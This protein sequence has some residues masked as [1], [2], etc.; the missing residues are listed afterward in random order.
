[1]KVREDNRSRLSEAVEMALKLSDGFV[2]LVS[3]GMPD[4]ELTEKYV[5]P[6]CEISL[7]DI[8]P[9]LF[10]FNAPAGACPDC[11]GLRLPHALLAGARREPRASARGRGFIPWKSMKHMIQKAE[12]LAEKK[13]WDISRPFGELPSEAQEAMLYGSDEVLPLVFTD[14]SWRL[15]IQRQVYGAHPVDRKSATTRRNPKITKKSLTATASRTSARPAKARG[16]SPRR[17]PSRSAATT[18]GS[19]RRCPSTS[20]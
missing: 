3:E 11:G 19:S 10:S 18:S 13:G 20:L 16:S 14:R 9:R 15:G 1:M 4:N 8:E 7:P 5:C 2:L 17:S 12:K 6:V